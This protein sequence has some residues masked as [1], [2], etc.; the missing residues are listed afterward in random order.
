MDGLQYILLEA[1][2]ANIVLDCNS[3]YTMQRPNI[4]PVVCLHHSLPVHVCELIRR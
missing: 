3:L 4:C 2:V 1:V